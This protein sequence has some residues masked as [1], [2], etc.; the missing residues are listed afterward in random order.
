MSANDTAIIALRHDR[1]GTLWAERFRSLLVQDLSGALLVVA[2]YVDLNALR[3]WIVDDPKD[4]RFCGYAEAVAERERTRQEWI[5]AVTMW[6]GKV[7]VVPE[8]L[9][10]AVHVGMPSRIV[11]DAIPGREFTG[12]VQRVISQADTRSRT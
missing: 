2:A 6:E 12:Q 5:K 11:F 9:I 1:F 10:V 3:A 8:R 4:Y 7:L